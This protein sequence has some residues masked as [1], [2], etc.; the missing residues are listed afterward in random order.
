MVA[1]LMLLVGVSRR[2]CM[3]VYQQRRALIVMH[4]WLEHIFKWPLFSCAM[5][6][7]WALLLL[8]DV[9]CAWHQFG[10]F[11]V[12]YAVASGSGLV[13]PVVVTGLV[14][15]ALASAQLVPKT[16]YVFCERTM[17]PFGRNSGMVLF[18][19]FTVLAVANIVLALCC[20]LSPANVRPHHCRCS[21]LACQASLYGRV[22]VPAAWAGALVFRAPRISVA[23]VRCRMRMDV[24]VNLHHSAGD[25]CGGEALYPAHGQRHGAGRAVT[26]GAHL[27]ASGAFPSRMRIIRAEISL[28]HARVV[29]SKNNRGCQRPEQVAK[30]VDEESVVDTVGWASLLIFELLV[31]QV[32]VSFLEWRHQRR[33]C[34]ASGY[35]AL[36]LLCDDRVASQR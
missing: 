17:G 9:S 33:E 14:V 22:Y 2:A 29:P 21:C 23:P 10:C 27:G 13:A 36:L 8:P 3:L 16:C 4:N 18:V 7:A 34:A 30:D 32:V 28:C 20:I 5:V 12:A 19:A 11:G 1:V 6:S 35:S 26:A 31:A 25:I 24:T 15:T